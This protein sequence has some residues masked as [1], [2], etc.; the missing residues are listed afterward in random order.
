M[1]PHSIW[2]LV[3]AQHWG[4]VLVQRFW[5]LCVGQV[6]AGSEQACWAQGSTL[7]FFTNIINWD[8]AE[9]NRVL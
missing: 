2:S 8:S 5:Q 1:A 3:L 9:I 7:S 4:L 6:S